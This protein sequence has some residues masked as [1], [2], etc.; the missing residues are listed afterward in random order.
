MFG[1]STWASNWGFASN[2]PRRAPR[3]DDNFDLFTN[4]VSWLRER[5]EDL[6]QMVQP[7]ARKEYVLDVP[8]QQQTR[9]LWLPGVLMLVGVIGLGGGVWLVRRR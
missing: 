4:C 3:G 1:D 8:E 2:P 7:K 9:M 6:G 5:P